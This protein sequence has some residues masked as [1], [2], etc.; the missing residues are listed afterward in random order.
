MPAPNGRDGVTREG[1]L[2]PSLLENAELYL[3]YDRS[4]GWPLLA[5]ALSEAAN[6]GSA[7]SLLAY[8]DQWVGRAVDGRWDP[9]VE[10]SSVIS[11]VDRPTKSAPTRAAELAD[12]A[13]F[14]SQLPPWGG[15]WATASCVGMPKPAKGDKLG[16]VRVK[17]TA[18]ILVI[19]TTNDPA[20]PYVGAEALV[21]RIQGS[22]LLTFE[23]TEHTA[24]GRGIST[25]IDDA[26]VAYLV[27]GTVP[28][29]GTR[30]APN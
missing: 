15:G 4:R 22:D 19:G 25:C 14:Q 18:P 6:T 21:K 30:C 16:D 3:L 12:V 28:A 5:D 29:S 1:V 9:L 7:P 13:T 11:C 20:T 23:S 27:D 10:A 24:F 8:A 17:G 2:T 26:V